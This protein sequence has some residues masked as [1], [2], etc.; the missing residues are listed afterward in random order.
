MIPIEKTFVI[1][2][3]FKVWSS[4]ASQLGLCSIKSVSIEVSSENFHSTKQVK[5]K[6]KGKVVSVLLTE[7]YAMIAYWG[8]EV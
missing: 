4:W 8:L 1:A 5:V 7:H 3:K 2:E 6:G